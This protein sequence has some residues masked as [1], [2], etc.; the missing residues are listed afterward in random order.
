[1]I[2]SLKTYPLLDGFRGAPVFDV[3]ALQEGLLRISAMVEDLPQI[4]ELDSNPF[5][6]QQ[7]GAVILDARVRIAT[8]KPTPFLGV[9]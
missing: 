5:V 2:Q 8:A 4:A 9:R 3:A 1:M 7:Q 6:V